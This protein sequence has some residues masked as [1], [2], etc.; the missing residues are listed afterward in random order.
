M[1]YAETKRHAHELFEWRPSVEFAY[2][3]FEMWG[4]RQ[5]DVA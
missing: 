5:V 3:G 2:I 1:A 4:S